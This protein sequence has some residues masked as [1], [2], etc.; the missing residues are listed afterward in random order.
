MGRSYVAWSQVAPPG[1]VFDGD[2]S[3]TLAT[4]SQLIGFILRCHTPEVAPG[5]VVVRVH[6][7]EPCLLGSSRSCLLPSLVD[8]EERILESGWQ[9]AFPSETALPAIGPAW[10]ELR[11]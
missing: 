2:G 3:P 7:R 6:G 1:V 11:H 8:A 10:V 5:Q 9:A 4:G